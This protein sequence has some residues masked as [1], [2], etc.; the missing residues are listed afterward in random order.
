MIRKLAFAGL[1]LALTGPLQTTPLAAEGP[2][3]TIE[4]GRYVCEL[5]ADVPG[6]V[7][8]EQ[9]DEGFEIAGAS[10][11]RSPQGN[12]TYLRRGDRVV[13]TS[14]PRNG[15]EY[16]VISASMVRKVENGQP[17]RLRCYHRG[18]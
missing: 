12:G 8:L 16:A 13:M 17:G 5:P 6:E 7:A 9:P 1:V 2:I 14:G 10:R 15:V 4:R 3:S 11:Y 18:R